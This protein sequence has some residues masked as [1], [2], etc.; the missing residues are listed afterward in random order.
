[1]YVLPVL[2]L[3]PDL[4]LLYLPQLVPFLSLVGSSL[5]VRRVLLGATGFVAQRLLHIREADTGEY[6]FGWISNPGGPKSR[7][8][9][10]LRDDCTVNSH[11]RKAQLF[12]GAN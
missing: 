3:L 11:S 12:G 4:L 10:L 9:C 6:C 2:P 5:L 7:V 8:C 1:V